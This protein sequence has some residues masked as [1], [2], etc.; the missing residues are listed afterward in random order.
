MC[1][2]PLNMARDTNNGYHLLDTSFFARIFIST[3]SNRTP[4]IFLQDSSHY[5]ISQMR[6]GNQEGLSH[7]STFIEQMSG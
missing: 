4:T 3:V 6:N 7:L 2:I 1:Q 5:Y